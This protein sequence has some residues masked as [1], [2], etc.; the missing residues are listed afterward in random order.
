MTD[1]LGCDVYSFFTSFKCARRE[2]SPALILSE[3][4]VGLILNLDWEDD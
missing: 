3:R 2:L 1:W 4:L